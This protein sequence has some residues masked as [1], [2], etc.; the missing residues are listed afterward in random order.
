MGGSKRLGEQV[1]GELGI[2]DLNDPRVVAE[3]DARVRTAR[4]ADAI[5]SRRYGLYFEEI[6]TD[7]Q[8]GVWTEAEHRERG[9]WGGNGDPCPHYK[10]YDGGVG[11]CRENELR[12]CDHEPGTPCEVWLDILRESQEEDGAARNRVAVGGT[13]DEDFPPGFPGRTPK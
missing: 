2:E 7:A 1:A 9:L 6:P 13:W 5:A 4:R 10:G 8:M 11:G 12:A 3:T